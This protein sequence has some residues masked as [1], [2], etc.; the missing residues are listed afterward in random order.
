MIGSL[1]NYKLILSIVLIFNGPL[2]MVLS[3][4]K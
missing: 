3:W 2:R 1:N 4:I